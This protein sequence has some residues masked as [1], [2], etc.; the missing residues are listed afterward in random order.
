M[1]ICG[2]V[3]QLPTLE[4]RLECRLDQ[5]VYMQIDIRRAH[6]YSPARR[7]VHVE[8][9]SEAGMPKNKVGRLLK[10]MYGCR[11]AGVNWEMCILD[12]MSVLGFEQGKSSPCIYWHKERNLRI[13]V[14]GDDFIV[15]GYYDDAKWLEA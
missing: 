3:A 7:V 4:S 14:Y 2:T 1:L 13:W 10:T 12:V 5:I 9:P 15:M 6:F 11:D 8:L